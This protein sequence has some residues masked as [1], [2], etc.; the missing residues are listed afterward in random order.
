MGYTG[1]KTIDEF[2]AKAKFVRISS[3]GLRESHPH[4]ILVTRESPNYPMSG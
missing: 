4:S 2:Q 1:S 3:A